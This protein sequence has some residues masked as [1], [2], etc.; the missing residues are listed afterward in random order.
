MPQPS[1]LR[2]VTPTPGCTM[3]DVAVSPLP[4]ATAAPMITCPY[5]QVLLEPNPVHRPPTPKFHMLVGTS[6]P[7]SSSPW[8]HPISATA[9]IEP[10][11]L[12]PSTFR[13]KGKSWFGMWRNWY[14]ADSSKVGLVVVSAAPVWAPADGACDDWADALAT[15]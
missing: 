12:R 13:P 4:S 2:T 10:K 14:E 8:A 6:I 5:G 9:P 1:P 7:S 11:C 15:S 3:N